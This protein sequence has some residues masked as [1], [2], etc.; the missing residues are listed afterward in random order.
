M[1]LEGHPRVSILFPEQ[2]E[3]A[4]VTLGRAFISDPP[5]LAIL[6]GVTDPQP[7]ARRLADVFRAALAIQARRGE[8]VL[9]VLDAGR[10][11]GVAVVEGTAFTTTA[12]LITAGIAH[13]PRLIGAIGF[14]G[15]RRLLALMDTLAKNHP[16]QPHI[17]LNFLGVDP[18]FQRRHCGHV[19]LE[20]L[21]ALAAD[22]TDVAGVYLE[23]ATEANVAYYASRGY[24]V[25]G[26]VH[27]LGVRMWQMFQTR[28]ARK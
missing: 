5:L 11:V 9:G 22:R 10:V 26:E 25:T 28:G 17:Y 23:T 13:T 20:R 3:Q 21:R 12:Q 6:P 1:T 2:Y 27:P 4:A 16:P 8:P 18:A 15:L 24:E 7:R 19:L 14:G